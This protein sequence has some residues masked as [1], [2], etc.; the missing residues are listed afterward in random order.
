MPLPRPTA[1]GRTSTGQNVLETGGAGAS[2]V[3]DGWLNRLLTLLPPHEARAIAISATVPLALRGRQEV[4]SYAPSALPAA[5]DDLLARVGQLYGGDQQ[6]HALWA[7]AM[8][9]RTLTSDL[10]ADS[11]RNAAATG[12]LAARLL[13]AANGA[14]LAMIETGGWDT[15]AS[16]AAGWRRN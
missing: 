4:A 7:E 14:R 16:S 1:I 8:Q 11:G 9:T 10:A 13:A 3:K 12:A 15:H 5:P 6:L 2:Q